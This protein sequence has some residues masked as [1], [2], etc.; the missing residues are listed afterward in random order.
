MY[1]VRADPP[2]RPDKR[3]QRSRIRQRSD[4]TMDRHVMPNHVGWQGHRSWARRDEHMHLKPVRL[5]ELNLAA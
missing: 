4:V 2:Q 3:H 5:H 1:D